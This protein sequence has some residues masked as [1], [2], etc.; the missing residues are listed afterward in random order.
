VTYCK[1]V[2][3]GEGSHFSDQAFEPVRGNI[4]I[5][6]VHGQRNT[7]SIRV[8]FPAYAGAHCAYPQMDGP[9]EFILVPSNVQR[10]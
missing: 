2:Y 7:G 5:S 3:A 6:V 8:T 10:R 1:E 9:A 4:Y